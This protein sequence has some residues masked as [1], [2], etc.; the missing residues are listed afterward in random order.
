MLLALLTT[1][2]WSATIEAQ[3]IQTLHEIG[4]P[5]FVVRD[6]EREQNARGFAPYSHSALADMKVHESVLRS[7]LQSGR[8]VSTEPWEEEWN[9]TLPRGAS[10]KDVLKSI[11]DI[12]AAEGNWTNVSRPENSDISVWEFID[13]TG[14]HW[15]TTA[16]AESSLTRNGCGCSIIITLKA[17]GSTSDPVL[18]TRKQL[19]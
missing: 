10:A 19:L 5:Q 1:I 16:R 2:M 17:L 3:V 14:N 11:N 7:I 12:W 13:K 15:I 8:S 4:S 6:L 18:A 9:V